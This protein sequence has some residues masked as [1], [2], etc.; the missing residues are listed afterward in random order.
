MSRGSIRRCRVSQRVKRPGRV[1]TKGSVRPGERAGVHHAPAGPGGYRAPAPFPP[2]PNE[3]RWAGVPPH[4]QAERMAGESSAARQ[5]ERVPGRSR[6]ARGDQ[7]AAGRSS[8]AS[9]VERMRGR[10]RPARRDQRAAGRIATGQGQRAAGGIATGRDQRAAGATRRDQHVAGESAA[11]HRHER[12]GQRAAAVAR[13]PVR[14]KH[15]WFGGG[16]DREPAAVRP[17]SAL[18]AVNAKVFQQHRR[19][20]R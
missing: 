12:V 3:R 6:G 19:A 17:A 20:A 18:G 5:G 8:A 11:A 1:Q 4:W 15:E 2:F 9:Q 14:R 7:R 13:Q 10:S 16:R